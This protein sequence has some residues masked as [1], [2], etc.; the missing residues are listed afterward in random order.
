MLVQGEKTGDLSAAQ[1]SQKRPLSGA[2]GNSKLI[3][4][5]VMHVTSPC[6]DSGRNENLY[7]PK[8]NIIVSCSNYDK[9]YH[10]KRLEIP[11][12]SSDD[13]EEHSLFTHQC[14]GSDNDVTSVQA[15][16]L[17]LVSI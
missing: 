13:F 10:M 12:E 4:T 9:R 3:H 14:S 8:D 11:S 2:N 15:S 5:L 1:W 7:H 17:R 16:I 6:E